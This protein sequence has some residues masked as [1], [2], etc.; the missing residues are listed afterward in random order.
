[1][2]DIVILYDRKILFAFQHRKHQNTNDDNADKQILLFRQFFFQENSGEQQRY[3]AYRGKDRCCNRSVSAHSVYV[4]QL[5]CGF[6][7]GSDDFISLLGQF[8]FNAFDLHKN[9]QNQSADCKCKLVRNVSNQ[10]DVFFR[11]ADERAC[12][13]FEEEN[14]KETSQCI[15]DRIAERHSKSNDCQFFTELL[16][17]IIDSFLF[18][19]S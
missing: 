9:K 18:F 8:K 15:D 6:T 4:S 1:M 19:I 3:H 5:T 16:F 17:S 10:F 14:V 2:L 7:N 12:F 11:Y 13:H